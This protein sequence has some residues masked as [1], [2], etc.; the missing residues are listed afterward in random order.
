MHGLG[1][2]HFNTVYFSPLAEIEIHLKRTHRTDAN[3][4]CVQCRTAKLDWHRIGCVRLILK[5]IWIAAML[6]FCLLERS[7]FNYVE[8]HSLA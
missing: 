7:R 6:F 3:Q 5:S 1:S 8:Q 2:C 4:K